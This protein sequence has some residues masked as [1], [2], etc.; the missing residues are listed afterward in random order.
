MLKF[1][2]LI[3]IILSFSFA[4][5]VGETISS[6]HQ[7]QNFPICYAPELDPNSDGIFNFAEYNGDL[8]PILIPCNFDEFL[9]KI[10]NPQCG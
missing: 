5:E 6:A 4:Y 1:H 8:L 2:H 9:K 7:N 10:C 3:L